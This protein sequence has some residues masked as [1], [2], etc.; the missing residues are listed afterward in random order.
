MGGLSD[1]RLAFWDHS[2][3]SNNSISM[4]SP[5]RGIFTHAIPFTNTIHGTTKRR[6]G[7]MVIEDT[8][9]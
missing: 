8:L 3:R 7:W 2:M 4:A 6:Q 9:K 5:E 1:H